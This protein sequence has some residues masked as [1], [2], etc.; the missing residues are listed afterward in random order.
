MS[1]KYDDILSMSYPHPSKHQRMEMRERAAQFSPFAAL[2]GYGDIID[3]EAR[4]VDERPMLSDDEKAIINEKLQMI[5]THPS[6]HVRLTCFSEDSL[7][8][9]GKITL[10]E[11]QAT[12]LDKEK[13]TLYLESGI[14][15]HFEDII[16]IEII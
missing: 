14:R 9:G 7:K 6:L 11:S 13:G 16:S 12:K 3:E 4:H 2:T 8:R 1:G 10:K 5:S 15:V